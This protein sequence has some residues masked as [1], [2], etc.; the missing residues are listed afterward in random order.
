MVLKLIASRAVVA[1]AVFR[2][3]AK[4]EMGAFLVGSETAAYR[5]DGNYLTGKLSGRVIGVIT[6]I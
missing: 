6:V 5:P 2:A 3:L 1:L 4:M